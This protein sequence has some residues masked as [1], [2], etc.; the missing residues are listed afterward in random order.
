MSSWPGREKTKETKG[1]S[2]IC[3]LKFCFREKQIEKLKEHFQKLN[4]SS[5]TKWNEVVKELSE[6][7]LFK[8]AEPL[9]QLT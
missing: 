9:E 3:Y 5:S 8:S 7:Q 1:K 6:D 2:R 4:I